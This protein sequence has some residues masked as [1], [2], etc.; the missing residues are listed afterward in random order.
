MRILF[1][2]H[3]KPQFLP[4]TII[5]QDEIV[6]GPNFNKVVIDG[7]MRFMGTPADMWDIRPMLREIPAGQ[8]PELV[9]VHADAT[10]GCLPVNFPG[11]L[12]R[13]LMVG[14][15]HHMAQPLRK[16]LGYAGT[17]GFK[18]IVCWNRHHAHFFRQAG[19]P[20]VF[21]MP[22]LTFG[23]PEVPRPARRGCQMAFFGQMGKFHP[24]RRRIV[25][26][27]T[28][29]KL[30]FVAGT[31]PRYDGLEL[32][33]RSLVAFN[34]SLNSEF[35]L[36]VFEATGM[37]AMLLTDRLCPH[38]GLD[39]FYKDGESMIC[40][41]SVDDMVDK[42]R[43]Y[44][45]HPDDALAIAREGEEVYRRYFTFEARRNAF[46][47]L[48]NGG[49]PPPQFL[50]LDEAR[51][52]LPA[53][54]EAGADL[55]RRRVALYEWVQECHR[56]EEA[57]CIDVAGAVPPQV[58]ADF[59]DLVRVSIRLCSTAATPLDP[60][61]EEVARAL[62]AT[63]LEKRDS[64][65]GADLLLTDLRSLLTTGVL[66]AVEQGLYRALFI[67]D[68]PKESREACAQDLSQAGFASIDDCPTLFVKSAGQTS[69]AAGAP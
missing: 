20:H 40:Y 61:L 46:F 5:D 68:I 67:W 12:P 16:V 25:D 14:D 63:A 44:L 53:V 34:S 60:R 27:I 39:L 43:H 21:W 62:G 31:M 2:T 33:G 22:G 8:A 6:A 69:A 50:L 37:G 36:R 17:A 13:V 55:L 24:R 65:A 4:A 59:S 30:P 18:V 26:A 1:T 41:D 42:A 10:A 15:T 35:N 49:K 38:A 29:N 48:L 54:G 64:L 52:R 56:T 3:A 23:I 47:Q 28:A 57:V 9:L 19:F 7:R 32:F 11:N 66:D 45:E 58:I 51:C